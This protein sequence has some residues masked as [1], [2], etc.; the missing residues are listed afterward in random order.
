MAFAIVDYVFVTY[1]FAAQH[2]GA[3][4]LYR[5]RVGRSAHRRTKIM[6]RLF[7]LGVGGVLVFLADVLAGAVAFQDRWIDGWFIVTWLVSAQDEI[8]AGAT[9]VLFV[10]TAAMLLVELRAS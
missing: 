9:L 2:F 6:D 8:R 4:S 3:L 10:A 7:A 1:H 5:L